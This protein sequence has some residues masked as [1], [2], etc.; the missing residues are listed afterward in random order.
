MNDDPAATTVEEDSGAR[1][2]RLA[3]EQLAYLAAV[4]GVDDLG[5]RVERLKLAEPRPLEF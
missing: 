1:A 4:V 5:G 2:E 3:D